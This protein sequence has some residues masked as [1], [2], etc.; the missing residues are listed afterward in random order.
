MGRSIAMTG[1][2]VLAAL[3]LG[4][5]AAAHHSY[6]MFD[7]SKPISLDGTVAKFEWTNPH[8]FIWLYA[9]KSGGGYALYGF[10]TG[11]PLRLEHIGWSRDSIKAGDKV[12]VEYL[13]LKD[14]RP[15]GNL[16][17]VGHADGKWLQ[18]AGGPTPSAPVTPAKP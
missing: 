1:S 16:I 11:S 17:R 13:P 18:G 7:A 9:A 14:G 15:G 3:A 5:S 6:S 4:G 2:A 12:T 10:E 8:A